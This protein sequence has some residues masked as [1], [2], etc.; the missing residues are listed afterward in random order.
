MTKVLLIV[1]LI[2]FYVDAQK[3]MEAFASLGGTLA[4]FGNR[5]AGVYTYNTNQ[6]SLAGLNDVEVSIYSE[7]RFLLSELLLVRGC[8]ALPALDGVVGMAVVRFGGKDCSEMRWELIYARQLMNELAVG[9]QFNYYSQVMRG[10]G[11]A[12]WV[13]ADVAMRLRVSDQLMLGVRYR[14]PVS[15]K[16]KKNSG[17]HVE[18]SVGFGIGYEPPGKVLIAMEITR[19]QMEKLDV[20]AGVLYKAWKDVDVIVGVQSAVAGLCIGALVNL[21]RFRSEVSVSFHPV[22]GLT[23]G[24]LFIFKP[25]KAEL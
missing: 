1:M 11:N 23:P 9:V 5:N 7:R 16:L 19:P 18:R 12:A 17:D 13:G 21:G 15:C 8:L 4:A 25:G 24:G 14:N 3:N 2:P 6:A 10:Y 20:R 22:L